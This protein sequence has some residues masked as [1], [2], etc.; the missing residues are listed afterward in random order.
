MVPA[1]TG[2]LDRV[3]P[4]F[5]AVAL[6]VVPDAA[7]L[8]AQGWDELETIVERALQQRPPRLRRQLRVLLRA[9]DAL[10]VVR[11]RRPFRGLE[12]ERRRLLLER[13]QDAPVLLLRRGVWGLRALV[14]MGY[15]GRAAAWEEIGYRPSL[16]GRG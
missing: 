3:R 8:D 15:Y 14:L 10:S 12:A 6:T 2:T 5:R 7:F 13:L 1:P 11:W 16:E 9:V 4:T